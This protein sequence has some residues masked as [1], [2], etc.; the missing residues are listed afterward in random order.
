MSKKDNWNFEI[1]YDVIRVNLKDRENCKNY[2]NDNKDLYIWK[3]KNS[4][5]FKNRFS[6]DFVEKIII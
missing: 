1:D 2:Y 5:Y 4:I 6:L 3:D